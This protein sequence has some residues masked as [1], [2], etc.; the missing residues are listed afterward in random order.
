MRQQTEVG[1]CNVAVD[2]GPRMQQLL[3]AGKGKETDCPP[4]ASEGIQPC[5]LLDNEGDP[6]RF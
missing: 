2:H 3:E 4:Q 6:V 1:V 5:Q